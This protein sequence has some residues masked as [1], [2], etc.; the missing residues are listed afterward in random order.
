MP[1]IDSGVSLAIVPHPESGGCE[2]ILTNSGPVTLWSVEFSIHEL[3]LDLFGLDDTHMPPEAR[4][5]PLTLGRLDPGQ[6]VRIHEPWPVES[7][8]CGPSGSGIYATCSLNEDGTGRHARRLRFTVHA[9]EGLPAPAP[10][11]QPPPGCGTGAAVGALLR[12]VFR[13][14]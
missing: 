8:R 7:F 11:P 14:R 5:P 12:R 6:V 13:G 1:I 10:S 3:S 4:W 2:L 9:S